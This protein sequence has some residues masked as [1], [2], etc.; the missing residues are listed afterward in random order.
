MVVL[1]RRLGRSPAREED[2]GVL[3]RRLPVL[4]AGALDSLCFLFGALG[5]LL[6]H[7][8]EYD[9][10]HA[11]LAGSPALAAAAAGRMLGKPVVVKLGGGAASAS[12]RCPR[13]R[14]SGA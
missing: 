6:K 14:R 2:S 13:A 1:T 4:G 11:H 7:G 3:I 12:S 10:I 8:A 9:A 5:W